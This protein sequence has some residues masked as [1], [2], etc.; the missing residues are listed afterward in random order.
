[1]NKIKK[2]LATLFIF[3]MITTFPG[4]V[5]SHSLLWLDDTRENIKDTHVAFR[6]TVE[7]EEKSDILLHLSGASYYVVYVDGELFTDGPDRYPPGH[8]VYQE[9]NLVLEKGKHIFAIHVH[10]HGVETRMLQA[11]DPFLYFRAF[12]GDE[13]VQINWKCMKL[14]GYLSAYKRVSPQLGWLEWKDTGANPENWKSKEF[15]DSDWPKPVEVQRDIGQ[16]RASG[17]N[18]VK[19]FSVP[20][21]MIEEGPVANFYGYEKDDPSARF[22]LRDLECEDFPP[23]GIWRRYD[24]GKIRLIRP[25]FLL[26]LPEGA[27]V[28]FAFSEYLRHDRVMPWINLSGDDTYNLVHFVAKGGKQ[29][30]FPHTPLAGRFV[31]VHILAPQKDIKI[32]EENFLER[33]YYSE[34]SG[35]FKTSDEQLNRIWKLGLETY[36][37]CSEDALVDNPTRERGQW[38]GD[39]VVGLRIGAYGYSDLKIIKNSL[40]H[41]AYSARDDGMVAGLSPGNLTYLSTFSALWTGVCL[42]YYKI[43]GDKKVLRDLFKYA[44]KNIEAFETNMLPEGVSNEAGWAFVDWGYVPN[45]GRS[46]MGLNL[47]YYEALNNM[48]EWS[49]ALSKNDKVEYYKQ[50][51]REMKQIIDTWFSGYISKESV[52]W[53]KIGYHRVVLGMRNGFIPERCK[54]EG[55]RFIK[56]HILNCFPNNQNAP[57]LSDP[58][59]NNPQLITPYFAHYA[60]PLLIE[61]GE[62][63]FVLDQYKICWGWMLEQNTTTCLEV[64]DTR[65]SHCHGWAGCPTWQLSGYVLGLHHA[66]EIGDNT[67]EFIFHRGY[68]DNAEGRIPLPGG[69]TIDISWEEKGSNVEY[70]VSSPVEI[71]IVIPE[72]DKYGLKKNYSFKG[73]KTLSLLIDQ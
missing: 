48:I 55:I 69:K 23:Q 12:E 8:P 57:R 28:E 71:T 50:L 2:K 45:E 54:K 72:N 66:N 43:S 73:T 9:R 1:M 3:L 7:L 17:I 42:D 13:E 61:N 51:S 49:Q 16:F 65:W 53:E 59:A 52:N 35:E 24:L 36:R 68:L 32:I 44:E 62:M 25:K 6:G 64:F 26:D 11:I 14:P 21:K 4:I 10:S 70:S 22:F 33:N 46:D 47:F 40:Y 38:M 18:E 31:E 20:F 41:H 63:D 56:A 15:D 30:F 37:S 60:F 67:F 34:P 27:V 58:D 29:E 19:N 39:A 5:N